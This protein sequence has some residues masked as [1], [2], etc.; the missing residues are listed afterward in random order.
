MTLF[1]AA[2]GP[3]GPRRRAVP[4]RIAIS[5]QICVK[6]KRHRIIRR[7]ETRSLH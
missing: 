5:D 2:E 4:T 7:H 6:L 3:T 1:V